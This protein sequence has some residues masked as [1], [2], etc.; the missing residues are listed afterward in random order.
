MDDA[1]AW[2]ISRV[3]VAVEDLD[4]PRLPSYDQERALQSIREAV[5]AYEHKRRTSAA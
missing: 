4:D 5:E 2:L 1:A 3:T